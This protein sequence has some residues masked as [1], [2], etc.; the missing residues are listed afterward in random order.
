MKI[1]QPNPLLT[2]IRL[3]V[4]LIVVGMVWAATFV[5][6]EAWKS[7]ASP[8][9]I[10]HARQLGT[11]LFTWA[12]DHNFTYPDGSSSTEVFQRLMDEGY[13]EPKVA[14]DLLYI[15]GMP[16][17]VPYPGSGPLKPE[18]VSWDLVAPVKDNANDR[19]PLLV[20]TGWELIFLP[21]APAE[22][23][24]K[25]LLNDP[26]TIKGL[27]VYRKGNSADYIPQEEVLNQPLMPEQMDLF[28][29]YRQLRP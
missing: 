17:K 16:G 20:S 9:S 27:F 13:L 8:A 12:S 2:W 23:R 7:T 29:G 1:Y 22:I 28:R 18:H 15:R 25:R 11:I 19:L 3:G 21:G 24:D 4:I 14:V 26:D 10:S 5:F 6:P